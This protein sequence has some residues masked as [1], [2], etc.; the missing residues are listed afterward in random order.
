M[1]GLNYIEPNIDFINEQE[2]MIT[3]TFFDILLIITK[4]KNLMF[5]KN[6]QIKMMTYT[7][8]LTS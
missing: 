1:D 3:L 6:P 5:I 8:L 7:F 4:S 2:N